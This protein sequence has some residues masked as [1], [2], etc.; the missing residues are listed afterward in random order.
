MR[1]APG[2]STHDRSGWP[3]ICLDSGDLRVECLPGKGCDVLSVR[4]W[5]RP[6]VLWS[7]PWGVR[8][9]GAVSGGGDDREVLMEQYAGGWQT[10]FPHLGAASTSYGVTW[11]MHG[12]AWL[13][14]FDVVDSAVTA[15]GAWLEAQTRLVRSPFRLRKRVEVDASTVTVTEEVIH[16]GGHDL[17]VRWGQHPAFSPA[18]LGPRARVTSSATRIEVDPD[19]V[20]ASADLRLGAVSE[21]PH[22]VGRD[23]YAVDLQQVPPVDARIDRMLYLT[24]FGDDG[25][26]VRLDDPDAGVAV[27]LSWDAAVMPYAWYWF[28]NCATPDFPWYAGVRTLALEP[29]TSPPGGVPMLLSPGEQRVHAVRLEVTTHPPDER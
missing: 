18:L 8:P 25:A 10:M 7:T 20:T 3:V 6:D 24:G 13:A 2:L 11:S 9:R 19:R 12:E 26:W 14:P 23:G 15:T 29:A 16:E 21:W 27:T 1:H 5:D 17:E 22:A 4:P 28:E